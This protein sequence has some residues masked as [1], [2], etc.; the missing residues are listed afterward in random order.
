MIAVPKA[1]ITIPAPES[2]VDLDLY[3]RVRKQVL[4]HDQDGAQLIAWSNDGREPPQCAEDLAAEII[5]IVLCA[6]RSAQAARTIETKVWA[7]LDA[8]CS[9]YTAF[10]YRAKAQAID[11]AWSERE[12]DFAAFQEVLGSGDESKII[13][14]C[15]TIPYV[16]AITRYQLAKNVGRD[17]PKPDI[18]LCRLAG[19]PDRGGGNAEFRFKACME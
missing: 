1:G 5:W 12:Q 8:G 9:A 15:G 6:G 11:R 18:W 10:G 16:G 14:W 7:A 4:E 19:L 17:V 3:L 13:Q 2:R